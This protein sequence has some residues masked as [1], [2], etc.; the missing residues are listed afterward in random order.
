MTG[1]ITFL[2]KRFHRKSIE[3]LQMT[4]GET[5]TITI[6][7]DESI[8]RSCLRLNIHP[9]HVMIEALLDEIHQRALLCAETNLETPAIR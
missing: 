2:Q 7:L 8:C 4:R 1:S 9:R 6:Y 5:A 3:P